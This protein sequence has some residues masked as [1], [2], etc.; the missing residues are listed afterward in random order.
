MAFKALCCPGTGIVISPN[1]SSLRQTVR[2]AWEEPTPTPS[3]E[4]NLEG[5]VPSEEG[6]LEGEVPSEEGNLE[7][8]APSEEG[9]LEGEVP[10]EEG[11]LE[12]VDGAKEI[13]SWEGQGWVRPANGLRPSPFRTYRK[14]ACSENPYPT[15]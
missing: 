13:P 6:N 1:T 9:N 12:V 7:R 3:E 2:T 15:A 11:N 8:E 14:S 5:E 10:S 4:G